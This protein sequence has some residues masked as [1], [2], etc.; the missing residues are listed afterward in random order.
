MNAWNGRREVTCSRLPISKE[1]A[2]VQ[3][4]SA[5]DRN[6]D[7]DQLIEIAFMAIDYKLFDQL[8]VLLSNLLEVS[9][10]KPFVRIA[11]A[12]GQYSRGALLDAIATLRTNLELF[13]DAVYTRALL[14]NFLKEQG[15]ED[16]EQFA[17]EALASVDTGIAADM[18]RIAL[19]KP[20]IPMPASGSGLA[21]ETASVLGV[22]RSHGR[23]A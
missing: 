14:A 3:S 13:P 17:H 15:Q 4:L 18:A 11:V 23:R 9:P 1:V 7:A 8:D 5:E 16:W 22:F 21:T 10:E 19:G 2:L 12:L 6:I 20:I